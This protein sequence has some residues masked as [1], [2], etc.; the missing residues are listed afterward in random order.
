MPL[1]SSL[2]APTPSAHCLT[3][4]ARL[5]HVFDLN[6]TTQILIFPC[7]TCS[8]SSTKQFGYPPKIL[9]HV[10]KIQRWLRILGL[11]PNCLMAYT[12]QVWH[13]KTKIWVVGSRSFTWTSPAM[14][15]NRSL[16]NLGQYLRGSWNYDLL[17][18]QKEHHGWTLTKFPTLKKLLLWLCSLFMAYIATS[19]AQN[20][21]PLSRLC[22][23]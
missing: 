13:G 16:L 10:R 1:L 8:L 19:R 14:P 18:W 12:E 4:I 21:C 22:F 11:C 5:V 15:V 7:W 20:S 17:L 3:G 23:I 9:S 6:L 2:C